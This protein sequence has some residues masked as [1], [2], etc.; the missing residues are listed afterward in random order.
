[1]G[2]DPEQAASR[3]ESREHW[4]TVYRTREGTGVSWYQQEPEWSLRMIRHSGLPPDRAVIDVGG[5]SSPL[6]GRLL[7]LGYRDITVLDVSSLALDR[8]RSQLGARGGEITW[9]CAD[10]RLFGPERRYGL[11]HD[12]ALFHFMTTDAERAAYVDALR[13]GL[14]PGGQAVIATFAVGGPNR[15]SGLEIVQY[16]ADKLLLELGPGFELREEARES[17]RTPS[18]GT[19]L[20]GWFRFERTG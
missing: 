16:D 13:R 8:N 1:M 11:W 3:P 7:D 12:R 19:Q 9:I 5:G 14:G 10:I 2:H 20:F 18:G 17:H 4:E 15:C 6:P